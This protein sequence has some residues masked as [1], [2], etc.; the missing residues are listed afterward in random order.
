M[1][2]K[3]FGKKGGDADLD[4]KTSKVKKKQKFAKKRKGKKDKKGKQPDSLIQ[5]MRIEESVAAASLDVVDSLKDSEGSAI[6]ELDEGLL[7]VAFTNEGLEGTG[8]DSK[9]EEFGSFSESLRSETI[10]SIALMN[11]LKRDVVGIIPSRETLLA[12]SEYN[13]VQDLVFHWAI[14][15][16]DVTDDSQLDVYFEQ[17]VTIGDILDVANN[18]TITFEIHDGQIKETIAT[19]GEATMTMDGID[20]VQDDNL[21]DGQDDEDDLFPNE[22]DSFENDSF[23]P[24]DEPTDTFDEPMD[25]TFDESNEPM[26]SFDDMDSFEP[27]DDDSMDGMDSIDSFDEVEAVFDGVDDTFDDN[28]DD[29]MSYE[30]ELEVAN[31]IENE[32]KRLTEHTFQNDELG[33]SINME[34]FDDYFDSIDV[35]QF[36]VSDKNDGELDR[37][38][39]KLRQDANTEL[40]RFRQH[41]IE[42]LRNKYASSMRDI[43]IKLTEALDYESYDTIYGEKYQEI[44]DMYDKEIRDIDRK[45]AERRDELQA[46]YNERREEF[47][48]Q[49]KVEAMTRFDMR[50]RDELES[51]IRR[52]HDDIRSDIVTSRDIKIAELLDDRRIIGKRLFDKA[53]ASLLRDIQS[54]F[55]DIARRELQMYDAFRKDMDAYL[56][57]HFADEVLRAKAE[58]EKMRQSHEAEAVRKKYE[59]LLNM[60]MEE[61]D[62]LERK[63]REKIQR[64]EQ[65]HREQI[66]ELQEDYAEKIRR[67]EQDNEKLSALLR[68]ANQSISMISEQKDKEVEHRM[69]MYEDTIKAK[70]REIE[71]ANERA[72][73][74]QKPF[75]FIIGAVALVF[76][77]LGVLFGF[78]FSANK[79]YQYAPGPEH[80]QEV[81]TISY[82]ETVPSH[83][84]HSFVFVNESE[85][86][87]VMDDTRNVA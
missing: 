35:A 37:V 73:R 54:A 17:E 48:E 55:Q 68:E 14:L 7:I 6:R 66:K 82:M 52:L 34:I 62:E 2:N 85:M 63:A 26:D 79:T 36:E 20:G 32:T 61:I 65:M 24:M 74:T 33:L 4:E 71:Y 31:T 25:E 15:P 28:I 43:H 23:E 12:L 8:I 60:R 10:E 16:F 41:N 58:A 72:N 44:H 21:F 78:L 13:F 80:Q 1:L 19:D 81:G 5:L 18:P 9:D 87:I 49:A 42:E 22:D 64:M 46:Q 56:R 83:D 40:R 76:L 67:K 3:F 39:N 29:N 27:L 51:E 86:V 50:Y 77:A 84:D 59:Q 53:T 30:E 57:R 69:K 11:D 70:E 45:V 75:Y 38:L 47:G